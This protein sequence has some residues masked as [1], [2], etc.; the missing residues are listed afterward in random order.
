MSWAPRFAG[1]PPSFRVVGFELVEV[2]PPYDVNGTTAV[3]AH[4]LVL[5]ALSGLALHHSGR[6]AQPQLDTRKR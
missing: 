2:S 6:A 4:R 5:E 1:S 3:N